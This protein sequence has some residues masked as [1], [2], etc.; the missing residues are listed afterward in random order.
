MRN[1][2]VKVMQSRADIGQCVKTQIPFFSANIGWIK[3]YHNL[4]VTNQ[5]NQSMCIELPNHDEGT[6]QQLAWTLMGQGLSLILI[7]AAIL[8]LKKRGMDGVF[9]DCVTVRGLYEMLG[10]QP[11]YEYEAWKYKGCLDY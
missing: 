4:T 6:I 7:S 10:F 5:V 8:D 11:V 9:V 3:A 2:S 1:R